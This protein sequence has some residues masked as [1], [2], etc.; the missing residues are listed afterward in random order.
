MKMVRMDLLFDIT[1]KSFLVQNLSLPEK[2][3]F[4]WKVLVELVFNLSLVDQS[5]SE[6]H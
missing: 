1:E 4:K 2:F 6:K 5:E 3:K